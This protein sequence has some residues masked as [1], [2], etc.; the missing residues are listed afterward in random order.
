MR[1]SEALQQHRSEVLALASQ[2]HVRSLQVF[3]SVAR[4]EDTDSSDLD[5]IAEFEEGATLFNAF[6][7]QESLE[8]L[9]KHR[10]E[11]ATREGLHPLIREQ[12]LREARML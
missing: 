1:P 8:A 3:G 7:L 6:A 12:V 5:L 11:L 2:H 9:L 4:G 10:V